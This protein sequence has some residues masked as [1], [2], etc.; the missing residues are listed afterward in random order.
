MKRC[1]RTDFATDAEME[2]CLIESGAQELYDIDVSRTDLVSNPAHGHKFLLFKEGKPKE[3]TQRKEKKT[4]EN[5]TGILLEEGI[6]NDT[7]DRIMSKWEDLESIE[8]DDKGVI[9]SL[10]DLIAKLEDAELRNGLAAI[11]AGYTGETTVE[12][13]AGELD[14][15]AR[16]LVAKSGGRMNLDVARGEILRNTSNGLLVAM[17]GGER[18]TVEE[19]FK[20]AATIS[21][22]DAESLRKIVNQLKTIGANNTSLPTEKICNLIS[23]WLN[24]VVGMQNT[25]REIDAL[26]DRMDSALQGLVGGTETASPGTATSFS[27]SERLTPIQYADAYKAL[28]R[29]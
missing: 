6:D 27:K 2:Q 23:Y 4:M 22:Q 21:E 14:T 26:N 13:S 11:L 10:R 1:K 5:L 8:K 7:T 29:Q 28:V 19:V 24:K 9:L 3:S 18:V 25:Q 15:L 16:E 17:Q 12:K 20:A